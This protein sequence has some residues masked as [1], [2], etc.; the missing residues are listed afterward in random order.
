M[1]RPATL[2]F[3]SCGERPDED[4]NAQLGENWLTRAIWR[5]SAL[6]KHSRKELTRPLSPQHLPPAAGKVREQRR[7]L[8]RDFYSS[9][10]SPG[11]PLCQGRQNNASE[12]RG[13]ALDAPPE[14]PTKQRADS[15]V[16]GKSSKKSAPES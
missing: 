3:Y 2:F 8:E 9:K 16:P 13:G 1:G 15:N 5:G 14:K 4:Q 7:P 11:A 10:V 12:G 6:I